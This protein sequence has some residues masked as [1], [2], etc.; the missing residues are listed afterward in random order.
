MKALALLLVLAAPSQREGPAPIA[1]ADKDVEMDARADGKRDE[2]IEKLKKLLPTV[3]DNA[4]KP[5]LI[6]RLAEMYWGKSKYARLRAMQSL[7]VSLDRWEKA[8][9]KGAAPA[10][11]REPASAEAA[12]YRAQALDLY[13]KIIDGY[14]QYDRRAEVLYSLATAQYDA[15]DVKPGVETFWQLIKEQPDSPYAADAWLQLGEHF[16]NTGKL[17]NAVKAY[18]SAAATKRPRVY[19]YATYKLAWCDY[20]LQ[21]YHGALQRFRGVV[22]YA[23]Q[24]HPNGS[25]EGFGDQ[26]RLQLVD[27]ALGDMVRAY[28]HLDSFEDAFA[29]YQSELPVD[30]ARSYL[31]SLAKRYGDE[32]KYMLQV[33]TYQRLNAEDV[34]AADAPANQVAI[35][36]AFAAMGRPDDVRREVR[37]LIDLYSPGSAWAAHNA[38]DPR[39]IENANAV[40]EA[41]LAKL[42]AE[43]HRSARATK[44]TEAYALTADL[45]REYLEKFPTSANA[46]KY[47]FYYAEVLFELKQWE[48]AAEQYSAVVAA[49]AKGEL[50]KP[51]AYTAILAWDKLIEGRAATKGALSPAQ[52]HLVEASDAFVQ[53]APN[54]EEVA[55][56]R[57]KAASQYYA[58]GLY[59]EAAKRS[60]EIIVKHPKHP[61]ARTSAEAIL[62]SFATRSDWAALAANARTIA[63]NRDLM[64][65]KAFAERVADFAQAAAF[66]EVLYVIEPKGNYADTAKAYSGFVRDYPRSKFGPQARYNAMLAYDKAH[67]F[68]GA[69]AIGAPVLSEPESEARTKVAMFTAE[70]HERVGELALAAAIL[71]TRKNDCDA[72]LRAANDREAVGDLDNAIADYKAVAEWQKSHG[73]AREASATAFHAGSLVKKRGDARATVSYFE[74]YNDTFAG[75]DS[76]RRL[77]ADYEAASAARSAGIKSRVQLDTIPKAFDKLSSSDKNVPCTRKAAAAAA[78]ATVEPEY[79]SAMAMTLTGAEREVNQKLVKKLERVDALQ[80]RYTDVLAIG[81]GTYGIAALYRIGTL[82]QNLSKSMF[83]SPCPKRLD[84]E[85]CTIYRQELGDRAFPLE[86]RAIEAFDKASSK[87]YEL[88]LYDEWLTKS[89]EALKVY[90][91]QRF[92]NVSAKASTPADSALMPP[93]ALGDAS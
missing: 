52:T 17:A 87:A 42:T 43:Q 48:R 7:D 1:S 5:E 60:Q 4:Q 31:R 26:D 41:E 6:Y 58:A 11:E 12:S 80:K 69:I 78:F 8:G 35:V 90:E 40:V 85:Q 21:D 66:N 19:A 25:E 30:R 10:L 16:F 89:Q 54:D 33:R 77:C 91:P 28:S 34:D 15:G 53:I 47:R 36:A 57:F 93:R 79:T 20:N 3:N 65:D 67:D 76:A 9:K 55:K 82:Y 32:G 75:G 56:I 86:E 70:L 63:Q 61:L 81:D 62:D 38:R 45:Y 72:L 13:R 88:G 14:P 68:K 39:V 22:G 23:R 71:E 50:A 27:E 2:A 37:K 51:A 59:D 18:E 29:Y 46:Y 84:A 92:P 24:Q 49:D 64:A 44:Q 83:D 73:K 74:Q